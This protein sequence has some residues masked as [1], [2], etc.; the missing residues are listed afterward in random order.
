VPLIDPR[1]AP[2]P[3]RRFVGYLAAWAG[4][5]LLFLSVSSGKLITYILPC[6]APFAILVAVGLERYLHEEK[7]FGASHP[8][9]VLRAAALVIAAAFAVLLALLG[10][11]Q[12]GVFGTIPFGPGELPKLAGF[13]ALLA[14]GSALGIYAAFASDRT[15]R[16]AALAGTGVALFLPIELMTPQVVLDD[17]A[18]AITVEHYAS[19]A[20]DA[21]VVSDASLAGTV[22]WVLKR[23]DIYVLSA[24]E[25]AYGLSYPEARH[26]R[27]DAIAL[28]HLVEK[29]AGRRDVLIICTR[30][31]AGDIEHVLPPRADRSEHG[32]VVVWR[33]PPGYGPGIPFS[34]IRNR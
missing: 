9:T 30:S 14:A 24:G 8:G 31:T 33:I 22:A 15:A 6:F 32:K 20:Q 26:R 18:P 5:P 23:N 11:A 1:A 28:A 3:N 21:I 27:L 4:L 10:A 17:V 16:L 29:S 13:A 7:E 25:L 12:A 2:A 34:M 19:A